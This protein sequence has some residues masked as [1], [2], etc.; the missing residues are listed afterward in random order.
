MRIHHSARG[1][2]VPFP[3]DAPGGSSTPLIQGTRGL[4]AA[5]CLSLY[6]TPFLNVAGSVIAP[7]AFTSGASGTSVNL[8]QQS[9]PVCMWASGSKHRDSP[10]GQ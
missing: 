2:H 8:S 9:P 5:G 6:A 10:T 1:P 7:L 4:F 3:G